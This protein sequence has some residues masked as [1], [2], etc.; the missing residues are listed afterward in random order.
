MIALL[1]KETDGIRPYWVGVVGFL[2]W[3]ASSHLLGDGPLTPMSE[4]VG[5]DWD[6]WGF[7]VSIFAFMLG[8][9]MVAREFRDG[10]V[11]FLDGLPVTRLQVYLAKVVA[12]LLPM[13]ALVLG[14]TLVKV[15]FIQASGT[16]HGLDAGPA[17]GLHLALLWALVF[18]SVGLGFAFS[19]LGGLGWGLYGVGWIAAMVASLTTAAVR[20]YLPL[21]GMLVVSWD[22][23]E[24][25]QLAGPIWLW[26]GIG[27]VGFVVSGVLF[28]GP[29]E[30][31]VATGSRVVG[32]LRTV[33]VGCGG[34]LVIGLSL[35]AIPGSIFAFADRLLA[36]TEVHQTEH[37]RFLFR[38][39]E[40][41]EAMALIAQAEAFHA[42]LSE[43]LGTEPF[44]L[45]IELM[46]GGRYH[47]GR[48]L[49]GKIRMSLIDGEATLAHELA[50][51]HA[52]A[53]SGWGASD[54][55]EH[56]RFFEEGV[57]MYYEDLLTGWGQD[58]SWA[59]AVWETDQ[60]RFDELVEDT[61]RGYT[62]DTFQ[63]YPLGRAFVGA[64]VEVE[65]PRAPACL[66]S[67]LADVGREPVAG[68][69]LWHGIAQ[70]CG[71]DL[72]AVV[73][74][75][76]DRLEAAAAELPLPL[77]RLTAHAIRGEVLRLR[78]H[79]AEARGWELMCRF[80]D[81]VDQPARDYEHVPVEDDG[82]C[83]VPSD[84]VSGSE[85]GYQ[86]GFLLPDSGTLVL[87]PWTTVAL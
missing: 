50:H 65:G 7:T 81:S 31:L 33:M 69:S 85:V 53:L 37:F 21:A 27:V 34:L 61:E 28:Q 17:L 56:L 29:G 5:D 57:G 68:L 55:Y 76:D 6:D 14:S 72:E 64:L 58:Q 44:P 36:A 43:E 45:D 2:L 73:A 83:E 20:P 3:F 4:V 86:L 87:L 23:T 9:A 41:E 60:A 40:K 70:T 80:R 67:A 26:T 25:T 77:P 24:A 79:D 48:F 78:V 22:G 39:D 18:G 52:F 46:G 71:Y 10:H 63:A 1:A 47:S 8:H 13:A 35:L 32:G 62:S 74:R 15:W 30:R 12:G 82:T 75:F 54:Q 51:A 66:L 38:T 16:P 11:E 42:R 49:G 59:A 19:W 84:I